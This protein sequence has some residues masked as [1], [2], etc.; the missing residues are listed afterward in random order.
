MAEHQEFICVTCP[1][2]CAIQA[3]IEDGELK[4]IEGEACRRGID[5]VRQ[6]LSDP[7]RMLTT[8]VQV[9]GGVLPLVPVRSRD[10]LPK[11]EILPVAALLRHVVLQAPVKEGQIVVADVLSTG[12]DIIASRDLDANEERGLGH[13]DV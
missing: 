4:E 3:V 5:W 13:P 1:M 2:G 10:A 11:D 12:V 9:E 7:R 8:T 6:E